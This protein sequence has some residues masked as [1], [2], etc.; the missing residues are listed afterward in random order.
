VFGFEPAFTTPATFAD[1]A[2]RVPPG[3]WDAER[4]PGAEQRVA[5]LLTSAR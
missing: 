3:L 2:D 4:V 1:F 5:A